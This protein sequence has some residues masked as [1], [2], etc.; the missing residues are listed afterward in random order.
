MRNI[1]IFILLFI[2]LAC[3]GK[4]NNS[5]NNIIISKIIL[6]KDDGNFITLKL[7][8]NKG[9]FDYQFD[10]LEIYILYYNKDNPTY[11]DAYDES[12]ISYFQFFEQYNNRIIDEIPEIVWHHNIR[13]SVINGFKYVDSFMF[14][15]HDF[16]DKQLTR[17]VYLSTKNY[18]IRIRITNNFYNAPE[19]EIL[20]DQIYQEV[21][22]YFKIFSSEAIILGRK[23]VVIWDFDNNGILRFSNDLINGQNKSKITNSWFV[24]SEEIL[25]KIQYK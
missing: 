21:P 5:L 2:T 1:L 22:Q 11:D 25:N 13:F 10:D 18:Y 15:V 19:R 16:L 24:K 12:N 3:S 9:Y 17:L 6:P 8:D 23:D 4:D 14:A 7:S 20:F